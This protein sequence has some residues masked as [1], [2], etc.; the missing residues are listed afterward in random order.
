MANTDQPH[1]D[2][3]HPLTDTE[4]VIEEQAEQQESRQ[5]FAGL[6]VIL[7]VLAVV[8]LG[9]F[10]FMSHRAHTPALSPGHEE[11]P[12]SVALLGGDG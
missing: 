8:I 9:T 12:A 3:D 6:W 2:T 5:A 10:V 1:A 11:R 7:G 4:I